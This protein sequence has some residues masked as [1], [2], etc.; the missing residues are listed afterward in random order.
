MLGSGVALPYRIFEA[1]LHINLLK[2]A[3][4]IYQFILNEAMLMVLQSLCMLDSN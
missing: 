2:N 1:K 4:I 3:S